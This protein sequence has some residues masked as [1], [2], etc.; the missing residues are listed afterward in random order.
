MGR[1]TPSQKIVKENIMVKRK[2]NLPSPAVLESLEAHLA[3][4]LRPV[5]PPKNF[6]QRLSRRVHIPEGQVIVNRLREWKRL[7]L[8]FGSVMSGMLLV[9]TLA[10]ALYYMV[11]R[12]RAA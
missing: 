12:R 3:G 9:I 8:A 4:A 5:A 11:G 2:E 6:V 1:K 10:R 7:L